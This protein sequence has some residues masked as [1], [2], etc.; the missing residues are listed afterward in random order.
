M[1]IFILLLY[2]LIS[3]PNELLPALQA[4]DYL[5]VADA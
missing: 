1:D 5:S 3:L 2:N 4:V